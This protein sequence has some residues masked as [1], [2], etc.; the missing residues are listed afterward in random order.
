MPE[1][2]RSRKEKKGNINDDN[3]ESQSDTTGEL[4]PDSENQDLLNEY[5]DFLNADDEEL[6]PGSENQDLLNE[7]LEFLADDEELPPDSENQDLL[8]E[9]LDFLNAD[10]EDP[11]ELDVP[12]ENE[13][14]TQE[15]VS[16][17]SIEQ[18]STPV[19]EIEPRASEARL[20]PRSI[21]D[22]GSIEQF[23]HTLGT[24]ED[25]GFLNEEEIR[26]L[27]V[28]L[29]DEWEGD[30]ISRQKPEHE[31]AHGSPERGLDR[32]STH[33]AAAEAASP[34]LADD[35]NSPGWLSS[36]SPKIYAPAPQQPS[37]DP[38]LFGITPSPPS[39]PSPPIYKLFF[40]RPKTPVQDAGQIDDPE[41][42]DNGGNP[43]SSVSNEPE[44]NMG[45]PSTDTEDLPQEIP[46]LP[47]EFTSGG[48]SVNVVGGDDKYDVVSFHGPVHGRDS[49][50]SR[51]LGEAFVNRYQ[52]RAGFRFNFLTPSDGAS[53]QTDPH[54]D[55][56]HQHSV[57]DD[58]VPQNPWDC[59]GQLPPGSPRKLPPILYPVGR[60][61][62]A[63]NMIPRGDLYPHGHGLLEPLYSEYPPLILE[64]QIPEPDF[65]MPLK[66]QPDTGVRWAPINTQ[67][68]LWQEYRSGPDPESIPK[69]KP[70]PPP[71][72]PPPDPPDPNEIIVA[73]E[74]SRL[75]R[76]RAQV[77][78]DGN[79]IVNPV[80]RAGKFRFQC[81][82]S[83]TNN[84]EDYEA[85]SID[86]EYIHLVLRQM[87][88]EQ[89]IEEAAAAESERRRI[90]I[91][92]HLQG[93]LQETQDSTQQ[94]ENTTQNTS[95]GV[96][97]WS[98][99]IRKRKRDSPDW[100]NDE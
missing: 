56:G 54:P 26:R 85:C 81:M 14:S 41:G 11:T 30:F 90:I 44:P 19:D 93:S 61:D 71:Q 64:P 66:M 75:P 67:S 88:L 63:Y 23:P 10:D 79:R 35:H 17:T 53:T 27:N 100:E 42:T 96:G 4:P 1:S 94:T 97:R 91:E 57:L 24:M 34:G 8:N 28:T 87:R 5:L 12:R 9:Y 45:H 46:S 73:P 39:T 22:D 32:I 31:Q 18:E 49:P 82:N 20:K 68:T 70:K 52:I 48:H 29:Y 43:T 95:T 99:V 80:G 16:G 62:S 6:P 72:K 74:Q 21:N 7:Y 98:G 58:L 51:L 59:S 84:N 36:N 55:L 83:C 13:A 38:S 50:I 89:E 3:T 78:S 69:R 60:G 77:D 65:P 15:G 47:A 2:P 76:P 25:F 33:A 37:F 92:Q 40:P 86:R